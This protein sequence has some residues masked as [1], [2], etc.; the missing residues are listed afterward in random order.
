MKTFTH[1]VPPGASAARL[2]RYLAD[3]LGVSRAKVMEAFAKGEVRVDGRRARKGDKAAPGSEVTAVLEAEPTPPLAQPE[4]P[5]AVLVE[6]PAFL[7]LDK[8]AGVPTHPLDEG[9]RGTLA[10]ALIAR[11][12]ECAA[13]G[14]DPRE[15]GFAHRLDVETSGTIIAA[16]SAAAWRA[17][18][19]LFGARKVDKRYLAL[20][21]GA[22]GEGGEIALP[23]AHHPKNPRR[24]IACPNDEDAARLSARPALSI[25]RV[26]ERLGDLALVEIRI[27]T[28]V[29]HQIR[30]HLA[31][32]GAPVAGDELYGGPQVPGLTRQFLHAQRLEL[33]H[34]L[35]G[36]PVAAEAP[37][38]PELELL[39]ARL[40]GA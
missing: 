27:P 33:P 9:E 16:R 15:C 17:L 37:L 6:D 40:R 25:Y 3:A 34:P 18:R 29:M 5:L 7:I 35:T 20:V 2:D 23:I 36:H 26:L 32:V 24:M 38:P 14:D 21:G 28:G 30:V 39:L 12:P 13:A 10:N 22:P 31:A 1:R 19:D 11:F 4:L 8:A